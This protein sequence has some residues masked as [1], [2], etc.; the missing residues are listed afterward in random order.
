MRNREVAALLE[1]IADYLEL[2]EE[3]SFK[4]RA[5]RR[6]AQVIEN[7][8]EDIEQL[9]K[10]E[11]AKGLKNLAGVGEAIAEK[12]SEFLETGKLRYYEDLKKSAGID[13][14]ELG[15]IPQLGPK[16]IKKL[17][18]A[19]GI[20]N[21][22]DLEEALKQHK[23]RDLPGMGPKTEEL[24]ARNLAFSKSSTRTPLG[25]ALAEAEQLLEEL[26]KKAPIDKLEVAGSIR[27]KKDT[28]GDIDILA[29]SPDSRKAMETFTALPQVLQIIVKGATKSSVRL[30]E[31][32][33]VDI[34]IVEERSWGAAL[35]YFTGSKE[36]NIALRKIAISKGYKLSEYGLFS[37]KTG[38]YLAGRDEQ[39]LYKKLGLPYIEPELRQD[40]G[41]LE[42]AKTGKLPALV[43]EKDIKGDLQ[44]HSVWSD[45]ADT[46]E[47]MARA[48][49]ELGHSYICI[50]D[51]AGRIPVTNP[52][53]KKRLPQYL[54]AIEK[55]NKKVEGIQIL[56]GLEVNITKD[57]SLDVPDSMLRQVDIALASIHSGVSG[58][59]EEIMRRL[60]RAMENQYAHI[61]AHPT[62]R[63]INRREGADIDIEQLCRKAKETKTVLEINASP[64]RMDLKDSHVRA[65]IQT[66]VRLSIGTDAHSM[67][68]LKNYLLGVY[69]ARRGWAGK[70]DII[71]TLPA[72]KMLNTL[73]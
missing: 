15:R 24:L 73:K 16:T 61:I 50:T 65:A 37:K 27:R 67:E 56:A 5:Y 44:M 54:K 33:Q 4:I 58:P 64:E 51:H 17:H 66:G 22:K 49:K 31:G 26:R 23:I 14:D 59:R 34:R 32:I 43:Q 41:E 55:A 13:M 36:H 48:A 18:K 40:S 68:T 57:G 11:G 42:A 8:S 19:L 30:K 7:L 2:Q 28:I 69:T 70:K 46:I 63:L 10:E 25:F 60:E 45:G 3:N 1:R 53:D 72:D 39:G 52:I 35:N 21:L 62:A 71:N 6:A 12:T 29:T 9:W 20:K 47:A 38:K